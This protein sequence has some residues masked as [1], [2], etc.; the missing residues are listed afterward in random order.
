MSADEDRHGLEAGD[1][2][3]VAQAL[4]LVP[5]SKSLMYALLEAGEIEHVAISSVG[6]SKGRKLILRASLEAYVDA[7]TVRRKVARLVSI[8]QVI[9]EEKKRA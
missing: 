7:H 4:E 2:V 9:R 1:L 6:S 3:T 5:I 8:D